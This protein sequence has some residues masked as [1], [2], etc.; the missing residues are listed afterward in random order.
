M[1]TAGELYEFVGVK[2]IPPF[3]V[4][5]ALPADQLAGH[6]I[7]FLDRRIVGVHHPLVVEVTGS[8]LK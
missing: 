4:G 3:P 5:H 6:T 8:T 7:F 1:R 2:S